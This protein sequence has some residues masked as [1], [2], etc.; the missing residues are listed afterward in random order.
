MG[1]RLA[2]PL[3]DFA[4]VVGV[5]E[6]T[7]RRW[8]RELGMP[9]YRLGGLVL[10]H[11]R[12]FEAWLRRHRDTPLDSLTSELEEEAHRRVEEQLRRG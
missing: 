9:T 5:S 3:K 7:A 2:Y 1:E 10:V 6:N 8:A 11:V 4:E 12:D